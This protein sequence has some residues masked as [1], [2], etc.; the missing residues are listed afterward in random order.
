MAGK[1]FLW[2]FPGI[3]KS[4]VKTKLRIVD[5][6]CESF[7]F[8]SQGGLPADPHTQ[9]HDE[10]IQRDTAYPENY[11]QYIHAVDADIVF[12]NCHVNLLET[13]DKEKLLMVY[14]S[15]ER[16]AEYL[17]RYVS[18]GAS[19]SYLD[20]MEASFEDMV[21]TVKNSPYRKY[22]IAAPDVYLQDLID[23]G[24]IMDQFISKQELTN[25]FAECIKLG[26]YKQEGPAAGKTP[27]E[28][29]QMLFDGSLS[30]DI[31]SLRKTLTEKK[32]ELEHEQ[33]LHDRR[34]GLSH[35][36]LRSKIM[37]GIVNGALSIRHTDVAPYSFGYEVVFS[38]KGTQNGKRWTCY[39]PLSEVAEQVACKIESAASSLDVSAM[40]TEIEAAERTKITSFIEESASGLQRRG[41]YTGHVATVR[42][43]HMGIAL[44]GIIQGHFQG[45]YSSYTTGT[46]NDTVRALVALKGF[47]LDCVHMLPSKPL[48]QFVVDYLKNH[49][50]DISTPEKLRDWIKENP[51][52]CAL[53]ENR[54]KVQINSKIIPPTTAKQQRTQERK[55]RHER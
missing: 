28:L 33:M 21:T 23:G 52:K 35:E 55:K 32:K 5:A 53:P 18:R 14:P 51:G 29:A 6:D 11:L 10:Q 38:P 22:E 15:P 45:D 20:Y 1:Y 31:G 30:L 2:G 26:I 7:K 27:A 25:I 41:N 3:G 16:K 39:C 54:G 47:C 9:T 19:R 4:S 42:D 49:G 8:V 48:V 17:Q 40:L 43:V 12:I 46:Q 24:V 34:G 44:D 36:E 13:L 37:E 50:T